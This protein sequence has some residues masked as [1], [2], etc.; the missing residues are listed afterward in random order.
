M[1]FQKLEKINLRN[2]IKRYFA[3]VINHTHYNLY[4]GV[5]NNYFS[6]LISVNKIDD[7]IELESWNKIIYNNQEQKL[8][9]EH[10]AQLITNVDKSL[11]FYSLNHYLKFPISLDLIDWL[12]ADTIIF[13]ETKNDYNKISYPYINSI[14]DKNTKWINDLVFNKSEESVVLFRNESFVICKDILW[15]D[16]SNSQFYILAIPT[17]QIKTI[18]DLT[19]SDIPLLEDIK[20]NCIQIAKSYGISPDKLYLFFHYH[21]SYYQL[22]LHVCI[23]EHPALETNYFRHYHLD[24]IINKLKIDPDYWKNATLKFELL[25]GTKL[26]NLFRDKLIFNQTF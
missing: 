1:K 19:G 2:E 12:K 3:N 17:K 20:Y 21:P 7:E 9:E 22:H 4:W 16:D 14:L 6:I 23:T 5:T 8:T 13:E 11:E 24:S 10:I 15:K 18:R 25:S 26:Y